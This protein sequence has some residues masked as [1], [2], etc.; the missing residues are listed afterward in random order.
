MKS[1]VWT[2]VC[3]NF[4]F[5]VKALMSLDYSHRHAE[6]IVK[7][8]FGRVPFNSSNDLR[9]NFVQ[10]FN[11]FDFKSDYTLAGKILYLS[12]N[13]CDKVTTIPNFSMFVILKYGLHQRL[14]NQISRE[15]NSE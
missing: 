11:H 1:D 8:I 12:T 6:N 5:T 3:P 10:N 9:Q 4:D 13:I 15:T 2:N 14:Q 7:V